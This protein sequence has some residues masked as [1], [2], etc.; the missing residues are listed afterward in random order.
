MNTT[1]LLPALS[2][3]YGQALILP[4]S[5]RLKFQKSIIEDQACFGKLSVM[6]KHP[7][8]RLTA[9]WEEKMNN[10]NVSDS[11]IELEICN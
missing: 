3:A 4:L 5:S 9:E 11:A 10:N 1:T 6:K 8:D 2:R 7:P